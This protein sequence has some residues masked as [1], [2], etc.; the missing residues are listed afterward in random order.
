MSLVP[1]ESHTR[2][3]SCSGFPSPFT[4][5]SVYRPTREALEVSEI[6][7]ACLGRQTDRQTDMF[8]GR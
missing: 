6:W 8:P 3:C 1:A 2:P 5:D 4:E 7:T